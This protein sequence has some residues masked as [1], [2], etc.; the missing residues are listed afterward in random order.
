MLSTYAQIYYEKGVG[1]AEETQEFL[2]GTDTKFFTN[3]PGN[4]LY[5]RFCSTLNVAKQFDCLVGYFRTS[6]FYRLY[7]SLDKVEKIRI[8]VGLNVDKQTFDIIQ[9]SIKD[10]LFE[11][12][13][14]IKERIF[15]SLMKKA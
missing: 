12:Q 15:Y 5:E 10:E 13:A 6:G 9:E 1:M 4:T 11:G 2:H 14:Q 3:E 8:L 7:K